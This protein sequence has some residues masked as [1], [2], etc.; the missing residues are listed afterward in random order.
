MN[1]LWLRVLLLG[2]EQQCCFEVTEA[3]A[4]AAIWDITLGHNTGEDNLRISDG[5]ATIEK[6]TLFA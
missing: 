2:H 3:D 6:A 5:K 1:T 4:P